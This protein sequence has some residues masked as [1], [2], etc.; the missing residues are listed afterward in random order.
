M[1]NFDQSRN[2]D[3]AVSRWSRGPRSSC[4]QEASIPDESN[5]V[6]KYLQLI[7]AWLLALCGTV[8]GLAFWDMQSQASQ[9]HA[10][11]D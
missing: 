10:G 11:G 6:M 3:A 4:C 9:Q 2:R 7:A 8:L 5:I 1:A